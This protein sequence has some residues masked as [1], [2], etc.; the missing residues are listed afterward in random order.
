MPGKFQR[1]MTLGNPTMET[2]SNSISH[3]RAAAAERRVRSAGAAARPT[4]HSVAVVQ[5]RPTTQDASLSSSGNQ[6]WESVQEYAMTLCMSVS[7]TSLCPWNWQTGF[8]Q[9]SYH[10]LSLHCVI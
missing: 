6:T 8:W 1:S 4:T 2:T 9:I 3:P 5:S 10:W 7:A